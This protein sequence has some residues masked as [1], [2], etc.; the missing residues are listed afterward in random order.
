MPGSGTGSPN[1]VWPCP[2]ELRREARKRQ[3]AWRSRRTCFK[4]GLKSAL[5]RF[6]EGVLN[7]WLHGL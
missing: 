1:I 5:A 7:A 3:A 6:D 2:M 4:L